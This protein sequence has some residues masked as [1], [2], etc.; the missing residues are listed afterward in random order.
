MSMLLEHLPYVNEQIGIQ[1][2]L[3]AKFSKQEWR[4]KLHVVNVEKLNALAKDLV[5]ADKKL[6]EA[7]NIVPPTPTKPNRF[8]IDPEELE[9]LPQELIQELSAAGRADKG[10]FAIVQV[11]DQ[12]GGI[13]SLDQILIG[14][15]KRTGEVIKRNTLSSRLFRMLPKKLA[16][17]IGSR[18]GIYSTRQLSDEEGARLLG[19]EPPPPDTEPQ[20]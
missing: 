3:A 15:Y 11:I 9:G 17:T 13:A 10:E 16:F 12:L 20:S 8:V 6:E 5:D 4:Q 1:T 14:L 7:Q 19:N 18:T 2:K